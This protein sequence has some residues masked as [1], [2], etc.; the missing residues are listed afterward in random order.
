MALA[1]PDRAVL[2]KAQRGDE[3]AF[4]LIVRQYE[5]P[6]FNYVFRT[7][8]NHH[9]AED[10]T[11]EIFLRV[12]QSLPRFSFQSLFTTW[13]FQVTKN[14]L[15]DEFRRRERRPTPVDLEDAPGLRAAEVPFD[16]GET[17]DAI[18][19]A[20][21]ELNLDLKLALLL[22][23]VVG[24]S[25]DEIADSLEITLATVKWRIYKAREQVQLALAAEGLG[26]ESSEA[27]P[28]AATAT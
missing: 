26:L 24:L 9:L 14:R 3:R 15:I 7:V 21:G 5:L 25:Y 27:A 11:Q 13:L 23:D 6:V 2:R 16:R 1:Q 8:R 4:A 28:D 20:I 17:I 19:R 10:I 22:R 12:F 18:W